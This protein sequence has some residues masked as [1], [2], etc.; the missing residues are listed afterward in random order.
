MLLSQTPNYSHL[1]VFGC[2]CLASTLSHNRSKFA[3]RARPCLFLGYPYGTKGY[4]LC[5][6]E[7]NTIFLSRDVT[8]RESIF[9]FKSSS[10]FSTESIVISPPRSYEFLQ[11]HTLRF[12][13]SQSNDSNNTV[14]TNITTNS[15]ILVSLLNHY[16][17][18][19][20][21]LQ[22][23]S[24]KFQNPLEFIN[25]HHILQIIIVI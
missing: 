12:P 7:N 11:S 21:L 25:I 3:P 18:L 14:D 9:P 22:L 23:L 16:M 19:N 4:K 24:I 15:L 20:Q 10:V 8:F 17:I 1:R 13:T 2:L 6:L 5:D